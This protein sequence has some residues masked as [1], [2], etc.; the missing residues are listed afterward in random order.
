MCFLLNWC[1]GSLIETRPVERLD[2]ASQIDHSFGLVA[3]TASP[4]TIRCRDI[5]ENAFLSIG[6]ARNPLEHHLKL[7]KQCLS[8]SRE[9]IP[10]KDR[11]SLGE[12]PPEKIQ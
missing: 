4:T 6:S 8:P 5:I 3:Q 12:T 10:S 7:H 1:Y 9:G 2:K 11:S